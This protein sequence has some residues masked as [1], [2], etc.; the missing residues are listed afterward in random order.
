MQ[1]GGKVG[2]KAFYFCTA[3]L[4]SAVSTWSKLSRRAPEWRDLFEATLRFLFA[5]ISSPSPPL[6]T[7]RS[8]PPLPSFRAEVTSRHP[9]HLRGSTVV[10]SSFIRAKFAICAP[11][12]TRLVSWRRRNQNV[13]NVG[14]GDRFHRLH[15]W[16]YNFGGYS[17]YRSFIRHFFPPSRL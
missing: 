16:E 11:E 9:R 2:G 4:A 10:I 5:L 14:H 8:G 3:R 6:A 7:V 13:E 17:I 1:K 15:E 12:R